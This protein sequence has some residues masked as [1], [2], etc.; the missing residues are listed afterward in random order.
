MQHY[1][2][3]VWYD[4]KDVFG[5]DC[6]ERYE[7][8]TVFADELNEAAIIRELNRIYEGHRFGIIIRDFR[9]ER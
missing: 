2:V 5:R 7:T 1:N 9:L 4:Y 8:I 3:E 6:T